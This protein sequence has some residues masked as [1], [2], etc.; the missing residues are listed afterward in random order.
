MGY[1]WVRLHMSL[2]CSRR[3]CRLDAGPTRNVAEW[4]MGMFS[5]WLDSLA[6][7]QF[8]ID[9]GGRFVF[10]PFG[11]R[12]TGYYVEAGDE[13]KLKALVTMYFLA[14]SLVYLLGSTAT[15]MFTQSLLSDERTSPLRRKL[16]LGF[17]VYS[18]RDGSS[19]SD[20]VGIY[21]RLRPYLGSSACTGHWSP[22]G[23]SGS[24]AAVSNIQIKAFPL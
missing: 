6:Q 13:P 2:A 9:T 12:R 16:E 11:P 15:F 1:Q 21:G 8:R 5:R 23:R 3:C 7:Q 20:S 4:A 24:R 19:N 17:T 14:R 22:L 18:T 10:V